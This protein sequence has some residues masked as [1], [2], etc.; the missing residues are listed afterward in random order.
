MAARGAAP[1]H[2]ACRQ[3]FARRS[4]LPPDPPS[5]HAPAP[6]S[7]GSGVIRLYRGGRAKPKLIDTINLQNFENA[8]VFTR[9]EKKFFPDK[10]DSKTSKS[11]KYSNHAK[12]RIFIYLHGPQRTSENA[13][14][15][16]DK[17]QKTC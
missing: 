16:L 6:N 15:K 4:L 8:Q 7:S 5:Y 10:N 11:S 13:H 1:S 12:R 9:S 17:F 3:S 14:R 2:Q